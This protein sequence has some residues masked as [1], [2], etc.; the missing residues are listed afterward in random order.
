[1]SLAPHKLRERWIDDPQT[2]AL[3][4]TTQRRTQCSWDQICQHLSLAV[5]LSVC[6]SKVAYKF[7]PHLTQVYKMSEG[8]QSPFNL[9]P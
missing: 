5:C 3:G 1:L 6:I 8:M 7:P 9:I 2:K 4:E